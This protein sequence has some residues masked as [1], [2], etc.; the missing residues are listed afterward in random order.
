MLT[1]FTDAVQYFI[2][3]NVNSKTIL[4]NMSNIDMRRHAA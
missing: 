2:A 1:L 3:L 4:V